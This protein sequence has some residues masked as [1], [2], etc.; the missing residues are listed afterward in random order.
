MNITPH[1]AAQLKATR[2][3]LN[4]AGDWFYANYEDSDYY[5]I[6]VRRRRPEWNKRRIRIRNKITA[7]LRAAVE[8]G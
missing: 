4:K 6:D 5:V 2:A 3:A 7:R 8:A 1:R